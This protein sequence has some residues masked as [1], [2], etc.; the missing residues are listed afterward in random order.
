MTS[1]SSR[2]E[3]RE[4]NCWRTA[5]VTGDEGWAASW[6]SR[7]R[8]YSVR[9]IFSRAARA[10]M[11]A[12]SWA[13]ASRDQHVGHER[14]ISAAPLRERAGLIEF[15]GAAGNHHSKSGAGGPVAPMLRPFNVVSCTDFGREL[16]KTSIPG[17]RVVAQVRLAAL[18]DPDH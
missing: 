5:E 10:S 7:R 14:A 15:R 17:D 2:S 11:R 3:K 18:S 6:W 12:R 9:E 13:G 8:R 4:A 1:G 16:L